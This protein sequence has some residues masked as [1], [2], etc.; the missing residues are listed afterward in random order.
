MKPYST[1]DL[2]ESMLSSA[3]LEV[4]DISIVWAFMR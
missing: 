4:Q 2:R 3:R 1:C